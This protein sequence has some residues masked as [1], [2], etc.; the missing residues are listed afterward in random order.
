MIVVT[1]ATGVVGRPL[2]ALLRDQGLDVRAVARSADAATLPAG[3]DVRRADLAR[4]E[5]AAGVLE[6]ADV[7]FVHP[8]AVG[9]AAEKL[10]ALAAES[11]VRR[12]VVLSAVNVDD[13]P[14]YQPSRANGDR[15]KEVED[16]VVTGGL[17]W[18]AVRSSTFA[19]NT[20]GLFGAQA[21]AG[22]ILRA[23]YGDFAEAPIHEMDLAAVIAQ[24]LVDDSLDG[25]RIP[26]TGP[27]SVTHEEMVGIIGEVTGRDL[28]FQEVPPEQAIRG[29]VARGLPEAFVTA[30]MGRYERGA[31]KPA[32]VTDEVERILGRQARTFT[33]WV[34][35]HA[36]AFQVPAG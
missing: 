8:R 11:G 32:E 19:V 24:A 36:D 2:V 33:R 6:G 35:D 30:L 14:A 20:I 17:P 12:V 10:V 23:P 29:M 1:G 18:V 34:A 31:G 3:V 7:L 9:E 27:Q 21:R 4:P 13:D 15:N 25:R 16:A 22:D 26:V 5:E 28:Q